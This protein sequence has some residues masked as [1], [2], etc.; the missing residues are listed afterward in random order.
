MMLAAKAHRVLGCSALACSPAKAEFVY[1]W[2]D[3]E[4]D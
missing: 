3:V 1:R 4:V 2:I